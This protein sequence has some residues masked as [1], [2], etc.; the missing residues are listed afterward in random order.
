MGGAGVN[1]TLPWE[2]IID[3]Q[4]L[5]K[6]SF[7]FCYVEIGLSFPYNNFHVSISLKC[8]SSRF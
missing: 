8:F 3:M 7:L 1:L 2:P 5:Q 4:F 6:M